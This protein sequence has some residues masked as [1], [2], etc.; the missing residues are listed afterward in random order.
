MTTAERAQQYRARRHERQR[1]ALRTPQH[2]TLNALLDELRASVK[3]GD[4]RAV[5]RI[6]VE[7][8]ART[9][10]NRDASRN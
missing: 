1:V 8:T 3:D 7:L 2:A 10:V 9:R 4:M 5:Q 6:G